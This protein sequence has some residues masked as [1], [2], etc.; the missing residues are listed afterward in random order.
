M[1]PKI[2]TGKP[3]GPSTQGQ[4]G[5][6]RTSPCPQVTKDKPAFCAIFTGTT[7]IARTGLMNPQQPKK[8]GQMFTNIFHSV[9]AAIKGTPPASSDV[10]TPINGHL[11]TF[12]MPGTVRTSTKPKMPPVKQGPPPPTLESSPIRF[13]SETAIGRQAFINVLEQKYKGSVLE[14]HAKDVLAACQTKQGKVDPILLASII[15][16]ECGDGTSKAAKNRW[17][18]VGYMTNGGSSLKNFKKDGIGIEGS[19]RISADNL[20]RNYIAKGNTT[21]EGIGAIYCPPD[22]END[23]YGT[24]GDWVPNMKSIYKD[25][26]LKAICESRQLMQAEQNSKRKLIS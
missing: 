2:E 21:I 20:Y 4:I 11:P 14:G 3:V 25:L 23:L 13:L 26:L 16:E 18:F 15:R 5:L 9:V 19:L 6:Q 1:G 10:Y 24:N 12:N 7:N 22:A 17:N 8:D